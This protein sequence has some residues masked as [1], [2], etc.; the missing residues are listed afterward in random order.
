MFF[1]FELFLK[2]IKYEKS[3][4]KTC[5]LISSWIWSKKYHNTRNYNKPYIVSGIYFHPHFSIINF[6]LKL[7]HTI[8][9]INIEGLKHF[10][11]GDFTINLLSNAPQITHYKESLKL[12]DVI[13]LINWPTRF[14]NKQTP[15]FLDHIYCNRNT[16]NVICGS[17]TYDISNHSPVFVS[18]RKNKMLQNNSLWCEILK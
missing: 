14:M 16:N 11:M 3:S 17:V 12:L 7:E 13:S 4:Y 2:N 9:K 5:M 15:S 6:Q 18:S 8:E 10:T 1:Y